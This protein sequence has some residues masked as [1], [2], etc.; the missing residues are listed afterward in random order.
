MDLGHRAKIFAPFAALKGFSES[1][2]AKDVVYRDRI[3]LSEDDRKELDKKLRILKGLTFNS[4]MARQNHVK[5]T[6][7]YYV[8][9]ADEN[10]DAFE[11]RGSYREISG[12]CQGVDT[13]LETIRVDR[14]S[15]NFDDILRLENMDGIFHKDWSSEYSDDGWE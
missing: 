2:A 9:C 7:V 5:V 11:F 14:T 15:I 1:I 4:R 10:H 3:E 8:P 6:V 12:I 13:V